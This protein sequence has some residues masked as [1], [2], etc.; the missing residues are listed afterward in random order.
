MAKKNLYIVQKGKITVANGDGTM[1]KMTQGD[2]FGDNFIQSNEVAVSQQTVTADEKTTCGVLSKEAIEC[3]IGDIN[4]LG[5]PLPHFQNQVHKKGK[6]DLADFVKSR[7]LGVG[8]CSKVWAVT[9]KKSGKA[10]ALKVMDKRECIRHYQVNG[11]IREKN[12][13]AAISHPFIVN[14]LWTFQ[15][16]VNLYMAMDLA[17]GGDLFSVIHNKQKARYGIPDTNSRFYAACILEALAQMHRQ[18]IVFRNLKP[19]NVLIDALGYAVLNDLGQAKIVTTKTLTLCGTP[20][21]LAPEILLQRG[22]DKGVDYWALGVIIFEMLTGRSPFH[23]PET[24]QARRW[25]TGPLTSLPLRCSR[26]V[27]PSSPPTR[28]T[29]SDG[30]CRSST[31]SPC[32]GA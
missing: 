27:C 22:H 3:V 24:N 18:H 8:R 2:Y 20:E 10:L 23:A 31:S 7:I 25:T 26:A 32:A 17:Q 9:H 21:Y 11:L 13:M 15:D 28:S 14:L 12:L 1:F 19:E 5:K 16:D 30:S 4:R 6:F 29:C